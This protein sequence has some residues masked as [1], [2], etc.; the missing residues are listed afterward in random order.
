[1][2]LVGR[3]V[4][5]LLLLG[6]MVVAARDIVQLHDT[7]SY[8]AIVV[9][10]LW[11]DLHVDSLNLAQAVIQRYLHPALWDPVIVWVLLLPAWLVFAVPGLGLSILCRRRRRSLA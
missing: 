1:M 7:G 4:G 10:K 5:W 6:A 2:R 8:E 3:A 9:G 11:H